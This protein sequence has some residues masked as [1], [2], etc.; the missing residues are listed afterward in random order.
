MELT[1]ANV[2]SVFKDCLFNEG[3]STSKAV[4]V[5]GI[6][7]T[8]G[9]HPERLKSHFNDIDGLLNQ[10]P[11]QFHEG[12]GGGWTFLNMCQNKDDEQWGEHLYMEQL[13]VLGIGVSRVKYCTS[14]DM[15][16]LF[17]GGMPYIVILKRKPRWFDN[18]KESDT[19]GKVKCTE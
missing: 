7:H 13:M 1:I 10:L 15:W 19:Y 14:R 3:E 12:K 9:L 8:Y 6:A 18:Q 16:T 17:P 11:E 4:I 2:E 5:R